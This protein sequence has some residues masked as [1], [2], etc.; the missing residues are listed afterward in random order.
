MEWGRKSYLGLLKSNVL[1]ISLSEI[2]ESE[3]SILPSSLYASGVG[4]GNK[5]GWW[6]QDFFLLPHG[7][8]V[9]LSDLS[10]VRYRNLVRVENL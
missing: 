5:E 4:Q 2:P 8:E 6:V 10:R 1:L 7:F 3:G 9:Y